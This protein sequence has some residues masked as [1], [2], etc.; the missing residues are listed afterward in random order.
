M[1]LIVKKYSPWLLNIG[2]F[3]V[4]LKEFFKYSKY[5]SV[6]NVN[7]PTK[8]ISKIIADY[9]V[10]EKGLT[11]PETRL[12]FGY[13][14]LK[15]L[16][17]LI[18]QF[19]DK[20]DKNDDQIIAAIGVIKEY[21]IFHLNKGFKLDDEI[22]DKINLLEKR[23]ANVAPT[24]QRRIN[25]RE[26]FKSSSSS[27]S[28]FATSR[29]SIRN[30][31]VNNPVEI[32]T[33]SKAVDLANSAPSSCNRQTTRVHVFKEKEIIKEILAIQG[34]NRGFGHLTD[35]LLIV[36]SNLEC[37]HG[38]SEVK[39][40]YVDGGIFAMNLLH[41]LHFYKT[42]ACPLNCNLSP[43]KEKAL[44]AICEIPAEEVFVVMI[45]VGN[46]PAE[47]EV[48]ASNRYSSSNFLKIH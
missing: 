12:G 13:D 2:V 18:N 22:L 47:L 6:T 40:P 10:I 38:V 30:F 3:W 16:I 48:P 5:S 23:C 39:G 15:S 34:G 21:K 28:D 31:D 32:E 19:L 26:Y 37:W 46:I 35:K 7:S 9:H 29:Y 24:V 42:A 20:Y 1:Y 25:N 27:F 14:R 11:M 45:V 44:R 43:S 41:S 17:S 4:Y 33:I 36:T 8:L